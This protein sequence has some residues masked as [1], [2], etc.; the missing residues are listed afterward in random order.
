MKR[1]RA[2]RIIKVVPIG[3]YYNLYY[4][5]IDR[6]LRFYFLCYYYLL[7]L[8]RHLIV[9]VVFGVTVRL[10]SDIGIHGSTYIRLVSSVGC[11]YFRRR[12]RREKE[13]VKMFS[14]RIEGDDDDD[15]AGKKSR[16]NGTIVI[17]VW[18]WKPGRV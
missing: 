11:G 7:L 14:C 4:I 13:S 17:V 1:T 12:R 18:W 2:S 8:T 9:V 15:I 16:G 6:E 10:A 3:Y 5:H